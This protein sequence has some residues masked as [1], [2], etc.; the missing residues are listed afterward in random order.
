MAYRR[1]KY[2]AFE[3]LHREIYG[4]YLSMQK[5]IEAMLEEQK[6]YME[7][8]RKNMLSV[9]ASSNIS[10]S[11]DYAYSVTLGRFDKKDITIAFD[12]GIL[13]ISGKKQT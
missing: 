7:G 12:S 11:G 13:T 5:H 6:Q 2:S 8:I 9:D 1:E 10:S 3:D 4:H